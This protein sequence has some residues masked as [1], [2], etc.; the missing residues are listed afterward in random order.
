MTIRQSDEIMVEAGEMTRIYRF[1]IIRTLEGY[2]VTLSVDLRQP[3]II[4]RFYTSFSEAYKVYSHSIV[5]VMDYSE[6]NPDTKVTVVRI[7]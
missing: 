3:E 5:S 7:R 1:A 2:A 4:T 6:I